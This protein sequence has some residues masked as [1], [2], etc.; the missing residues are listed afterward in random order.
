MHEFGFFS[1]LWDSYATA[2]PP[3]RFAP[4]FHKT[5]ACRAWSSRDV[6]NPESAPTEV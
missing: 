2:G 4:R 5:A 1:A 3:D 6:A